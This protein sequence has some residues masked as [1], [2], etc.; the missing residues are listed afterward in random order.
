VLSRAGFLLL[1]SW[2][3]LTGLVADMN[4]RN[5]PY[6]HHVHEILRTWA[7]AATSSP[8]IVAPVEG[9]ASDARERVSD[10]LPYRGSMEHPILLVRFD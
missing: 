6:F 9:G 4:W 8:A 3:F 10:K 5:S 1:G 2:V 7:N